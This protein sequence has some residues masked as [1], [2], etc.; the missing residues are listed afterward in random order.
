MRN[1]IVVTVNAKA[2]SE[3]VNMATYLFLSSDIFFT[4]GKEDSK[5]SKK[6]EL[7]VLLQFMA[8]E[9]GISIVLKVSVSDY[10]KRCFGSFM[11]I[12]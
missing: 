2:F 10:C 8:T 11:C 4:V 7:V 12:L 6:M 5:R 9:N 1:Y 3:K